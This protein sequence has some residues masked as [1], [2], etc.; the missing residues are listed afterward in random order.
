MG[1]ISK[2]QKVINEI[3]YRG[4]VCRIALCVDGKPYIIPM[5]YG[6]KDG[7]IYLHTSINSMKLELIRRNNFICFEVDTDLELVVNEDPCKTSMRYKSVI[8]CG[9]AYIIEDNTEK[10]NALNIITLKYLGR[11]YTYKS[12]DLNRTAVIKIV[13]EEASAKISGY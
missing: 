3:L 8:G 2:D 13:V 6:Y 9:S 7:I 5:N 12:S 11:R 4:Q 10:T 1:V